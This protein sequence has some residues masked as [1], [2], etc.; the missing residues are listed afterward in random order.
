MAHDLDREAHDTN[1]MRLYATG[2]NAWNQLNFQ[3]SSAA[4]IDPLPQD[5]SSFTCILQAPRIEQPKSQ[6]ASTHG[7][8][9]HFFYSEPVISSRHSSGTAHISLPPN[10]QCKRQPA[11]AQPDSPR[12]LMRTGHLHASSC[13]RGSRSPATRKSQ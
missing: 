13:P 7:Q 5:L 8:L 12:R 6:L 9:S 4:E 2:F 1:V 3:G 11:P 10:V